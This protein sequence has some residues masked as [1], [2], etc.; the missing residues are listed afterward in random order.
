M[1]YNKFGHHDPD[2]R[3]YVLAEEARAIRSGEKEP[4]PLVIRAEMGECITITFQNQ[5]DP[6]ETRAFFKDSTTLSMHTH[7]V[8]FDVLGSDGVVVGYDYM[9]GNKAPQKNS[10][11]DIVKKEKK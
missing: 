2:G 11:G 1:K 6:P 3:I 4:E 7:F 10:Q 9:Q 5:L 8:G